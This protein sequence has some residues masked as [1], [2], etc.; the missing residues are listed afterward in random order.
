MLG[1]LCFLGNYARGWEEGRFQRLGGETFGF[2]VGAGKGGLD[3]IFHLILL[4]KFN[5][6][7]VKFRLKIK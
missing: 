4:I 5:F 6:I 2:V 7:N 1:K 3:S